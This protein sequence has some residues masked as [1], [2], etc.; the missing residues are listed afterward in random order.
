MNVHTPRS[1]ESISWGLP[2]RSSRR[3][4]P[5]RGFPYLSDIW[6]EFRHK[7]YG[8]CLVS[9][10]D[11]AGGRIPSGVADLVNVTILD[12]GLYETRVK[13]PDLN[14]TEA[15]PHSED[16]SRG[17]YLEV[18]Q[19]MGAEGNL[20]QVN[21][22][23]VGRLEDQIE[24]AIEDFSMAACAASD[25]LVKPATQAELVNLPKLAQLADALKHFN[26][27][28]ITAREAGDSFLERCRSIVML[29]DLLNDAGLDTP[30]HVFGA[31]KPYEVL[32][33]FL[34]G[35]D[36]FDGLS[37]LRWSLRDYGSV[38]IDET[39]TEDMQWTLTDWELHAAQ[40]TQNLT[41]LFRLQQAM[42]E[43]AVSGCLEALIAEFPIARK[44]ARVADIAGAELR[45][46]RRAKWVEAAAVS[47]R[48]LGQH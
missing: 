47:F 1:A 41:L 21:F 35:A 9:A 22:D 37:W 3:R 18:V 17:Q 45:S 8:V 40:C 31:I 7:L 33:Y 19:C 25:F 34:C 6:E 11:V 15:S 32:A 48:G 46:Q 16:W 38:P 13:K 2:H 10:F 27:I 44:A 28:G 26:V 36:I 39:A 4:F 42:Q 24:L 30:V 23:Y 43:Y 12:S 5:S 29:R 14:A 20:I